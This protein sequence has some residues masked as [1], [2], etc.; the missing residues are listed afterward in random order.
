MLFLSVL[1]SKDHALC[2]V[3]LLQAAGS[4]HRSAA[5]LQQ[6]HTA[7]TLQGRREHSGQLKLADGSQEEDAV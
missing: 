1:V 3:P 6:T 2:F 5:G 4:G 7:A